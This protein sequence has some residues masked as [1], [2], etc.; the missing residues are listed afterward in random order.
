[1]HYRK[2]ALSTTYFQ[3]DHPENAC[4]RKWME[5]FRTRNDLQSSADVWLHVLRYYLDTP[6]WEIISHASKIHKMYG[7]NGFLDLSTGCS[8]NP[9]A[10]HVHSLAYETQA[11]RQNGFGLWEGS[12]A[13]SP[14]LHR[15]YVVSPQIAIILRSILLRPETL[16]NRNHSVELSSALTDIN[17]HPPTPSYRNGDKVLHYNNEADFDRYRASKEAEEDTF[18][19]QITMLTPSQT[20]AINAII[21]KNTRPTGYVTFIS[22]DAMLNTTRK[23]CSHFFNFFRFPKYELLLPH[24]TKFYCSPLSRGHFTRDQYD[25]L[26]SVI[27]DN[28]TDAKI[29]S[30]L[31]SIVDEAFNFTSEYNKAYR[32]FLLCSTESPPPTCIFAERYRQVI[33]TST[34]SM[35]GV[36]GPP[37]R[38]LR[39]Q[40]S[41]KLVET[42]PQQESNA[43]FKVMSN[44]LAR[45]GLVFEKT[46]G[47]SPDEAALDELLH[48]VVVVG[49]LSWLGKN[50]HDYVNAVVKVA[51]FMTGQPTLQLFEK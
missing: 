27:F 21:L 41:L 37:P 4:V 48:K 34:G 51:G 7:K 22:K 14:G 6:H 32:M 13:G 47:L 30:L 45:L 16:E 36:F 2:D 9:E 28:C 11:D 5:S 33:S 25:E 43:L 26:A 49:I 29:W 42:L 19:F 50:R 38:T 46:D 20:H 15:L 24:L 23:F 17:Q 35:T 40:P 10:E 44:M 8:V 31:R 39:P 3:E 12:A 1:M 18:A